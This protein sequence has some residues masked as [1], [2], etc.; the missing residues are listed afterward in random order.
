[1]NGW[2]LDEYTRHIVPKLKMLGATLHNAGLAPPY[3][4]K[5]A[6]CQDIVN[7]VALRVEPATAEES[8]RI[9]RLRDVI[10]TEGLGFRQPGHDV[11]EFHVSVAYLLKYLDNEERHSLKKELEEHIM[12]WPLEFEL[13]SPEFCLFDDMHAFYRQFYLSTTP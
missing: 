5:L 11:Y 6:G 8:S 2:S 7:G 4:M 13:G 12:R 3:R 9:R 1:M 10:A